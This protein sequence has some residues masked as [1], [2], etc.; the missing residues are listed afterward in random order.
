[1][2]S[3]TLET[4]PATPGEQCF[5]LLAATAA[6]DDDEALYLRHHRERLALDLQWL[7][8]NVRPEAAILEVGAS[9]Y[10]LTRAAAGAGYRVAT[11]DFSSRW[12][13]E[14]AVR[15]GV[16]WSPCDIEREPLPFP[17]DAFDEVLFNEIFEHLRID[18]PFT[19][20]E[21]L[22]VLRPGGR[23]W[24][25]TPNL[26]SLR[27]SANLALR[28]EA[29]AV[30]AGGVYNQ[31]RN[32]RDGGHMLHVREYTGPEVVAF[33]Q[34]AGFAVEVLRYRGRFHNGFANAACVVMPRL[35]PYFSVISRKAARS[36]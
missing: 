21:I 14:R 29:W 15:L 13:R 36:R 25:S 35:R 9:P 27:G 32:L 8:D 34:A 19:A 12:N 30:S 2:R 17:D 4:L 3:V 20:G 31:Y 6:A 28:Q 11:V 10:C 16:A 24:L 22:R 33:L 7:L 1:M 5:A 26:L 23:L 18:L